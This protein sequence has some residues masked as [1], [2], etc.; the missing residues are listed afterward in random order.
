MRKWPTFVAYGLGFG[1]IV[2]YY[3]SAYLDGSIGRSAIAWLC[4]AVLLWFRQ[5]CRP[6][7]TAV[8]FLALAIVSLFWAPITFDGI[9]ALMTW[10]L[11]IGAFGV[12]YSGF[13]EPIF[14]G[15]LWG[16]G[17]NSLVILGQLAGFHPVF[18]AEVP[19]GLF[20]NRDLSAEA[21]L[22]VAIPLVAQSRWKM[23]PLVL[24][25]LLLPQSRAVLFVGAGLILLAG[26]R[27]IP[28]WAMIGI[29]AAILAV[30]IG[31]TA[32]KHIHS[33]LSRLAL[34]SDTW[35][36]VT[37][38][39][40]GAGQFYS[41]FPATNWSFT[42]SRPEHA[43]NDW[44][45]ILYEYGPLGLVLALAFAAYIAGC[46]YDRRWQW[47][48]IALCGLCLVSFSLHN[49]ATAVLGFVAGGRLYGCGAL[50]GDRD[51]RATVAYFARGALARI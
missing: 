35:R 18:E 44:L 26:W 39:G 24:P 23:L 4:I 9:W 36:G 17:I 31:V 29:V 45:E 25:S 6:P 15:A 30:F 14:E 12:G 49:A 38:I 51:G 27:R 22:L 7:H 46:N 2:G 47:T 20:G 28:I 8:A 41:A 1:L 40:H 13:A 43:H 34:W 48:W 10:L 32:L 11:L 16:M 33:D 42:G 50:V 3:P 5:D 37:W 19:A 21:A